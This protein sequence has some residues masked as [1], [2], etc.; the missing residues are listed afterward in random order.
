M[1]LLDHMVT[2]DSTF[3]VLL[4]CFPKQLGRL[5]FASAMWRSSDFSTSSPTPVNSCLSSDSRPGGCEVVP[6]CGFDLHF[7]KPNP[8]KHHIML[9]AICVSSLGKCLFRSLAHF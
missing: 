5:T 1:K 8:V 9:I 6:Q 7:P 4:N 2:W 3:E